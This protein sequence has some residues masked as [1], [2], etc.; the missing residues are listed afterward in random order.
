MDFSDALNRLVA[1]EL[2]A[3]GQAGDGE[4]AAGVVADL[5]SAL[6]VAIAL[7]TDGIPSGIE[8]MLAGSEQVV[9]EVAA[10]KAPVARMVASARNDARKG[11]F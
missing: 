5:A 7:V 10:E 4:R 2:A 3:A 9:A 11:R 1:N 8:A 6:G